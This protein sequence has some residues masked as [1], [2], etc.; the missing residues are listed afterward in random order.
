MKINYYLSLDDGHKWDRAIAEAMALF[1][2][3]PGHADAASDAVVGVR[4][5][6]DTELPLTV[7]TEIHFF[8]VLASVTP[9]TLQSAGCYED[10]SLSSAAGRL[11]RFNI[12]QLMR[13]VAGYDP[14][15][16]GILRGVRPTKIVHRLLDAN[17][18]LAAINQRL[19]AGYGIA[20]EKAALLTEIAIRQR[21]F[22]L[23]PTAE[24][25]K[26]IGVYIGIPF[27]PSRCL[28][29]SFPA[30]VLPSDQQ[31]VAVFM[32]AL[33]VDMAAA[34]AV[35][36]VQGLSVQSIYIGGGTPTSLAGED[37]SDLLETTQRLFAGP[38]TLE[39][40]VEA[41][42]P[43]SINDEKIAAMER[44]GVTRVS[45][46]PQ[47]MQEKTLKLI[48]RMHS[49]QDIINTFGKIRQTGQ[50]VVNMDLIAGLPGESETD[51]QDTLE[52]IRPLQPD[53]LTVHTLAMKKGSRL[54]L[55][56][57][58][59]VLP[60]SRQ[61]AGML[62]RAADFAAAV[63]MQPYYLYRQK[64]MTGNLENIGYA[65]P[66]RECLY[67]IQ[68]ME[69]RQTIIGIGLAAATKVVN[70]CTMQLARCYNPKDLA[71]YIRDVGKHC[72]LR[73][74]LLAKLFAD[75]EE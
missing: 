7:A 36:A 12:L 57:S 20:L 50:F 25:D 68:M 26:S 69:E 13:A 22:L 45:V 42:R 1:E 24:I 16:W 66:G 10:E 17:V 55:S 32:A 74:G 63:A 29:C 65:L 49:V 58:V 40:T 15:P 28:Y 35:I 67:N 52:Q 73:K 61:T 11:I 44:C 4:N 27:C 34:A 72:E 51:F 31:S 71:T 54:S 37:F 5:H 46:N 3:A 6:V 21:R 39:F 18:S 70:T 64:H 47:S 38:A 23:P 43:D 33:K 8:G 30:Y 53:N 14:G 62:R 41:G 9:L 75:E 2:I 19:T 56:P 48:G 60:D 59:W